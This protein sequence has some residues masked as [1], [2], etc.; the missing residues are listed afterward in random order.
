MLAFL[1]E[2]ILSKHKILVLPSYARIIY[3]IVWQQCPPCFLLNWHL[4]LL[5]WDVEEWN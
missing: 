3:I 4:D 1:T 5:P 2:L